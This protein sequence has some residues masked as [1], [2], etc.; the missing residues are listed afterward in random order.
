MTNTNCKNLAVSSKSG[1]IK[2]YKNNDFSSHSMFT[3]TNNFENIKSTNL[4]EIFEENKIEQC[5]LLKLDCEGAEYE[6]L[7]N[8][9][10]EEYKKI[11]QIFLEYH[12]DNNE[13]LLKELITKLKENNFRI[14]NSKNTECLGY[15]FAE[16]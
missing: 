12:I 8:V 16:K 3:Q 10:K 2:F 6:I 9:S 1:Y 13:N 11:N 14:K 4:K 5:N 7:L 15:I